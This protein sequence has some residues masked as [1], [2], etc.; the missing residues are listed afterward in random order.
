MRVRVDPI[1]CQGY[2]I[3][4]E[5][6]PRHFVRDDWGLAQSSDADAEPSDPDLARAV[7]QCPI[8]AI[9]WIGDPPGSGH[10]PGA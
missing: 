9:R 7:E 8:K 10:T 4:L 5:L 3:C 6:S 1:K 2:G